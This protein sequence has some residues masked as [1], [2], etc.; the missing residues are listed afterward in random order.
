MQA[1]QIKSN[2]RRRASPDISSGDIPT[3][4]KRPRRIL[5]PTQ[6]KEKM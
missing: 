2:A 6:A 3:E 4:E 5:S 1:N